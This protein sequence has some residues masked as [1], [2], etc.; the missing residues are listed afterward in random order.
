MN[1]TLKL[2]ALLA[3]ASL[4]FPA[5]LVEKHAAAGTGDLLLANLLLALCAETV[6]LRD[7]LAV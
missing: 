6:S 3:F 2:S 7:E 5:D 1:A 4:A